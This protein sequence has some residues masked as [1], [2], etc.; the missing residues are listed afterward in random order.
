MF[1]HLPGMARKLIP[2]IA[3]IVFAILASTTDIF[4][5]AVHHTVAKLFLDFGEK[6]K[7]LVVN[8][9]IAAIYLNLA[10]LAY[11]PL[12]DG[13]SKLVE[14]SH[15]KE[16]Y[17][18][19]IKKALRLAYWAV[20]LMIAVT[21][22]AP[23]FLS[24][25][26]VDLGLFTAAVLVTLKDDVTDV[27]R[28]VFLQ[29]SPRFC[30]GDKIKVV[31]IDGC[32]GKVTDVSLLITT[33]ETDKGTMTVPNRTVWNGAVLKYTSTC[34][35]D[36]QEPDS[37][38]TAAGQDGGNVGGPLHQISTALKSFVRGDSSGDSTK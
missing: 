26:V 30:Q 36:G 25:V 4:S 37:D 28:G 9:I 24:R 34:P 1:K 17:Q 29:F 13:W 23:D 7:P 16:R 14:H 10:Y 20:A 8:L 32:E 2:S 5:V 12:R 31:G 6:V 27:V 33:I 18:L 15:A 21:I 38:A 3:L 19:L 11:H 22:L 35:A